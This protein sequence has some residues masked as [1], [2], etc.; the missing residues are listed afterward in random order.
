M[1][2]IIDGKAIAVKIRTEIA[3][4]VKALK[5][6]GV[7]PGLAVVL[8]G[9]D[10]SSRVYVRMKE[11]ACH[12]AGIFSDEYKLP[13]D[14]SEAELLALVQRMNHDPRVHGILVQLPLPK[15]ID[16]QT[17]IAAIAPP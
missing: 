17:V 2:K 4:G 5:E 1:A 10:S 15:Q 7:T 12:E 14:T 16:E 6:K 11:K 13:V 3:E 8:V 9:D